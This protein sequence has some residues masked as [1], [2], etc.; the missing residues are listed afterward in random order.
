MKA[1]RSPFRFTDSPACSQVLGPGLENP[2]PHLRGMFLVILILIFT[3]I[4][5]H[6]VKEK[7]ATLK[8]CFVLLKNPYVL[9]M[10]LGI[11]LYVG[12]EAARCQASQFPGGKIRLRLGEGLFGTLFFFI[13]LMTGRFLWG[14]TE[15]GSLQKNLLPH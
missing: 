13:S 6:A 4:E 3:K 15:T 9:L 11:F 8:S 10:V 12:S 14:D 5:E 1:I 7:P 2:F